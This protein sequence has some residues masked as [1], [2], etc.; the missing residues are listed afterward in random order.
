MLERASR[1]T[2]DD[3][4]RHYARAMTERRRFPRRRDVTHEI[5]GRIRPLNGISIAMQAGLVDAAAASREV[6]AIG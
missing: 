2:P 4:V 3:G 6:A 1:L 5:L